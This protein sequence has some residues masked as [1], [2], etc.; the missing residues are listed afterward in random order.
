MEWMIGHWLECTE[1]REVSETWSG[2]DQLIVG[3]G[4]TRR[5]GVAPS[6]EWMRIGPGSQGGRSFFASPQGGA[7]TEFPLQAAQGANLVFSIPQHDFPQRV[8]YSR[9]G[10]VLTGAIEGTMNGQERRITWTYRQAQLGE[11]CPRFE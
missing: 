11:H 1:G 3:V 10:D 9:T 4:I 8:V 6:F 5:P 2:N 7:V